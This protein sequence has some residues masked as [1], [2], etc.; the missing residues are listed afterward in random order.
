MITNKKRNLF[1]TIL[2]GAS[3]F[4]SLCASVDAEKMYQD[5]MDTLVNVYP[6]EN[7]EQ[8]L[9]VLDKALSDVNYFKRNVEWRFM[10]SQRESSVGEIFFGSMFAVSGAVF[11]LSTPFGDPKARIEALLFGIV[12]GG[13]SL[14]IFTWRSVDCYLAKKELFKLNAVIAKLEAAKIELQISK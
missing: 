14:A 6:M 13:T 7:S 4:Q 11:L 12:N 2:L 9:E 1:R 5:I 8:R 10:R 3:I